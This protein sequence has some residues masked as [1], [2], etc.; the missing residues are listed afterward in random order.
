MKTVI[1]PFFVALISCNLPE[2]PLEESKVVEEIN[3]YEVGK[4]ISAI[5]QSELLKNVSS[6]MQE[7]GPVYAIKYCNVH[8]TPLTDS[9][10]K[11]FG[12]NISRLSLKARNPE[13]IPVSKEEEDL[14]NAYLR[15]SSTGSSLNDTI[16]RSEKSVIYY[17]PILIGMEAC[18]KCHGQ[19][20]SDISKET[21]AA[22][23]E[24]YPEDNAVNYKMGEFRGL[25]KVLFYK[26]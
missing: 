5:A 4:E 18:L 16:L 21:H 1:I 13:N 11:Q 19:T 6:A 24:L 17:R 15:H 22:I 3:Y 26:K 20:E 25:W 23:L 9:L 8:A 7:G 12:C 2:I 10:S 14:L